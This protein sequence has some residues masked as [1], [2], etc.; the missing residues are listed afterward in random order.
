MRPVRTAA[1]VLLA[2]VLLVA[3][4]AHFAIA[5]EF[6][7]QVPTFLPL[8]EEIVLVSGVVELVLGA[9]LLL[10]AGRHD[11]RRAVLG[12]VVAVFFVAVFPG[13]VWQ[14]VDG[15]PSFGLDTATARVVRLLF[16]PLLVVWA[17]WCTGGWEWLHRAAGRLRPH[18]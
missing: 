3:G 5:E 2:A 4:V 9:A 17:L 12:V 10:P 7:G 14:A 16:Q 8:R 18:P 15:S 11:D 1:R 13:N 6:L